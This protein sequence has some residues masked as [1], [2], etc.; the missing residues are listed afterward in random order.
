[1]RS[2]YLASAAPPA[3]ETSPPADKQVGH[4]G[5]DQSY[6]PID[7]RDVDPVV[8]F[9]N[10]DVLVVSDVDLVDQGPAGGWTR[11]E[12]RPALR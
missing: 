5:A 2:G 11:R 4:P 3:G 7:D 6:E 8:E 9:A 10:G 1:V 12:R